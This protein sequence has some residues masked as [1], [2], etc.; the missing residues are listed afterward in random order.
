MSPKNRSIQEKIEF[1]SY[2]IRKIV[3]GWKFVP[4]CKIKYSADDKPLNNEPIY[5]GYVFKGDGLTVINHGIFC[6]EWIVCLED[7]KKEIAVINED[8]IYFFKGIFTPF[9]E[10]TLIKIYNN[11]FLR[12]F[13]NNEMKLFFETKNSFFLKAKCDVIN[14]FVSSKI[15]PVTYDGEGVYVWK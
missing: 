10:E 14:D 5:Y 4:V 3:F 7:T 9:N 12:I 6:K 15:N 13:L 1:S 11:F 8:T 2:E